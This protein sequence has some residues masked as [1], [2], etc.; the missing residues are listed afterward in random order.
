MFEVVWRR[1]A[2]VTLAVLVAA[3]AALLTL[4]RI[5]LGIPPTAERRSVETGAASVQLLVDLP[6]SA[7][8]KTGRPLEGL[9]SRAGVLA[10]FIETPPVIERVARTAG[11]DVDEIAVHGAASPGGT[12]GRATSAEQ[13]ATEILAEDS[14]HRLVA[15]PELK[16]PV[17]SLFAGAPTPEAATR[18]VSAAA[19]VLPAY[20]R[21]LQDRHQVRA[22]Q[23][24]Q[25]RQ[26]GGATG[27]WV[28]RGADYTIAGLAFLAA[29]IVWALLLAGLRRLREMLVRERARLAHESPS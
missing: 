12:R 13:R 22:E 8:A 29:L 1:R 3:A 17:I 4:Y 14:E 10:Q 11:L 27:G 28:N 26:F 24:L 9:A 19:Q 5:E 25:I 6:Q 18:L 16:V 15:S 20:M 2:R 23:R 21:E 7:I